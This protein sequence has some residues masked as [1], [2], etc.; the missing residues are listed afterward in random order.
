MDGAGACT[1]ISIKRRKETNDSKASVT[2]DAVPYKKPPPPA[3]QITFQ[4][5]PVVHSPRQ[6][7]AV[8]GYIMMLSVSVI[9]QGNYLLLVY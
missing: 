1:A 7:E 2:A 8:A 4:K 3:M 5:P 6:L 9:G